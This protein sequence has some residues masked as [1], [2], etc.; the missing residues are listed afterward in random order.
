MQFSL[1]FFSAT[2]DSTS[3]EK[4][5]LLLDA[6]R[7]ADQ[8][9]FSAVWIPERHFHPFGGLY[10]NPAVLGAALAT[11]TSR[12][13]IRA[14][15]V[16]LPLQHVARVAEEWS[17]VDNLSGGRVEISF[18]SGWQRNDFVLA[19]ENYER[20]KSMLEGAVDEV[21]RLWR[22]ESVPFGEEKVQTFPRPLQ[23]ELPIW[24]TSAGTPATAELAGRMGAGL[25]THLVGQTY[26]ELAE[27]VRRY[28][29][30]SMDATGQPGR[31][32]LMLHTFLGRDRERARATAKPP[33][34]R[35]L[36]SAANLRAS[37]PARQIPEQHLTEEDWDIMLEHA[38]GRYMS[39][40]LIGDPAGCAAVVEQA[41]QAGVDEIS[42]L[43]DFVESYEEVMTGL[44]LLAELA[45]LAA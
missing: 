41:A 28:R 37:M 8:A 20:R 15:S 11:T 9:G 44:P 33:L 3:S 30:A 18:A 21:R 12:V 7:Y 23:A 22:G 31:V 45:K 42:C 1:S 34:K 38:A 10:P 36:R 14:G 4:Y 19:P 39:G 6:A 43:I 5:K 27:L 26:G 17:V 2:G 35:Y 16:V 13:G 24:M 29:V 32:A 25:L 40:A